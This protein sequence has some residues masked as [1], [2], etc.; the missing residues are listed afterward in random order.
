MTMFQ[1]EVAKMNRRIFLTLSGCVLATLPPAALS[2][3]AKVYR[4]GYLHP[5]DSSD[6]L[7]VAFQRA[8]KDFG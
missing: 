8:L 7:Y 1:G 4:I 3:Q 5:T 2:Q 6:V